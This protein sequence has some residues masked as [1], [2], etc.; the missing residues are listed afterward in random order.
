MRCAHAQTLQEFSKLH[1][2]LTSIQASFTYFDSDRTN[3]LAQN[4][5]VA[6][7]R[8]AGAWRVGGIQR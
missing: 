3:T 5:V 1:G 4:E 6:A 8:Q 7:L 2:F